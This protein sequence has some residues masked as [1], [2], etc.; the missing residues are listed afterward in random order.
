LAFAERVVYWEAGLEGF[1]RYPMLGVGLGNA[2][3]LFEEGMPPFGSRLTEIRR[4]LELTNPNFPNPKS[5]WVRLLAETG[6]VGFSA[7]A[8]WLI[9][10]GAAGF[11]LT[12]AAS[13]RQQAIGLAGLLS[14]GAQAIEGFSLD[15]FALPQLWIMM[16]LVTGQGVSLRTA[17]LAGG[18]DLK[19]RGDGDAGEE[20]GK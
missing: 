8:T 15:T 7:F 17:A 18:P 3:F 20:I 10:L 14:L 9:V 2:G 1:R 12:R 11:G 13:G 6:V 16:G 4:A 19:P 5:L